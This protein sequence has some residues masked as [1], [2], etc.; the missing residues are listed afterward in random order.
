MKKWLIIFLFVPT[1]L[2]GQIINTYAGG[3]GALGDGGPATSANISIFVS[4]AMDYNQNIYVADANH[5]R[6]RK[7]NY[8]TGI[9]ST[10]AGNG[11]AGFFGDGG[12]ATNAELNKPTYVSVDKFGN[13][14]ISDTYNNRIRKVDIATGNINTYVGD[15]VSGYNGDGILATTASLNLPSGL[16]LDS[17]ENLYFID[18]NNQ[19]VRKVDT[20]GIITTIAGNGIPGYSGD[21]GLATNAEIHGPFQINLD[22]YGNIYIADQVNGRVRKVNVHTDIITSV[23]GIGSL[24]FSGDGGPA[25]NAQIGPSGIAFDINGNMYV[26]DHDNE[27]IRK[28]DTF[29]IITSIAGGGSAGFGGDG[30]PAT[31]CE[32]HFP[33]GIVVE[34]CGNLFFADEEN[35]RVRI[36]AYS[37][38]LTIPNIS[39]SG[40]ISC[41]IGTMVTVNATVINAGSSYLIEWMN[42]GVEFNTTIVP[43]VTYIKPPGIDTITARVVPTGYGCW[44]S[45]ISAWHIVTVNTE[46]ILPISKYTNVQIWPNPTQDLLNIIDDEVINNI[47]VS[48]LI[49]QII[50]NKDYNTCN[51]QLNLHQLP[52][53]IYIVKLKSNEETS[54]A[55]I[56]KQ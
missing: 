22:K 15:G 47:T 10:V 40:M 37:P 1:I 12:I 3:G 4:L 13:I 54:I 18:C 53:G 21:G 28:I 56:I 48:N 35:S 51:I 44:D 19:R 23:V 39:L 17:T 5:N 32:M 14:F 31:A 49:G 16:I 2:N 7:I 25:T 9:I 20:F 45:T 41:P 50:I 36:I 52:Q 26:S 6:I 43:T 29:G 55:K 30:S 46:G 8:I 24:G 27:R 11:I 34:K 33:E 38:I 42:H